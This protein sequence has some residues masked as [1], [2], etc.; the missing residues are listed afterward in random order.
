M[1]AFFSREGTSGLAGP[2]TTSKEPD[3][4]DLE[5]RPAYLRFFFFFFPSH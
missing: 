4:Q 1:G 3:L 5:E 2:K